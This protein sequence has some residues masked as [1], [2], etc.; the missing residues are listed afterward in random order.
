MAANN[1]SAGPAPTENEAADVSGK[2]SAAR[3]RSLQ[4]CEPLKTE[5]FV[6]QS[7]PDASPVRWH[8]AHTTWFFETFLLR[9]FVEGYESPEPQYEYLFNSYY[10][11]V[12]EQY[13]RSRRGLLTRPT[14]AEI[15]EWRARVDEGVSELLEHPPAA[16]ATEIARVC[17]IGI[18]HEQQHQELMVTDLK[19]AFSHNPLGPVYAGKPKKSQADAP[20]MIWQSFPEGIREIGTSGPGFHFDNEGPRHRVFQEAFEIAG[21]PITN[22]E[23]LAFIEDR[24]YER[25]ELWLSDGWDAVQRNHWRAPLYWFER[26]GLWWHYT[27]AGFAPIDRA[28]PVAHVSYYE[29]DAYARWAGAR[30]PREDE[31]EVAASDQPVH[32]NFAESGVFAPLPCEERNTITQCFGDVWEWTAS[33]YVA[34][35]GY[36]PPAGAL[37]EYNGKFMCDQWVLRGG[38]CASPASHM[39][40]SYRNFFP[41]GARWQ[42][43]GIRLARDADGGNR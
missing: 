43:S 35:P 26:E 19:H 42:F 31:W 1:A 34:Y 6:V 4:L 29:A 30:L 23:F 14:V 2:F 11:A 12:G 10:N 3:A 32:G 5:D 20:P 27:L 37:G 38:S 15:Y 9:P 17:E 25:P 16:H 18:H 28:A 13:P 36:E 39:R 33:P 22:G 41:A 21:R 7:M 24:G 40:A 8:L